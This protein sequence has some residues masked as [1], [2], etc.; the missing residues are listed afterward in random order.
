MK[1]INKDIAV[2]YL[3]T[4]K[5]MTLIATI[6][7]LIGMSLYIFM[8]SMLVGFDRISNDTI[9]KN[10][11]QIR[12]FKDDAISQ[13]LYHEEGVQNI[14][15]NP[16]IVP[17]SDA[18]DNPNEIINLIQ[19]EDF[20]TTISPQIT[21]TVFYNIG[22]LQVPGT[23]TG[24]NPEQANQ[25]FNIKSNIVEGDF[26][27]MNNNI[28]AIA[29]GRGIAKNLSLSIGDN[30]NI[31]SS[32]GVSRNLKVVAIF[33]TNNTILDKTKSYINL[34]A[35]QQLLL[36]GN[37]YITDINVSI[38][39]PEKATIQGQ[40]LGKITGY[41]AESWLEANESIMAA[42]KMRRLVIT[43]VSLTILIV[44]GFGIYNILNMT[45][46]QKIN[47]IAILKAIGFKGK[48]VISIFLTQ[49]LTVGFIGIIGGIL[50]ASLFIAI[51][52]TV[53]IGGDI[54]YFPI[55]FEVQ[56]FIQGIIIGGLITFL[57]GYL[58]AKKAAQVDPISIFR[59]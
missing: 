58:P 48:D 2:T 29:L 32:K 53:Y 34:N 24:V 31:T 16:K 6:G 14:I 3:I 50:L 13:P 49:A 11:P 59:K 4:G 46:S 1:N 39:D 55:G 42:F 8:N 35:A 52:Q 7:V 5:R 18:I 43:F 44:A 20:V 54:G 47:D 10:S 17:A 19:K 21:T 57:A 38:K 41:K 12:I 36:Q 9:F 22:K 25:M 26:D 28:N 30:I 27:N 56:K 40:L 23:V 45:V 33:K 15:I 37:T 51:L